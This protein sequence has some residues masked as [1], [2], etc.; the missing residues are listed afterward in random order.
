M[1]DLP[2]ELE[3]TQEEF[4]SIERGLVPEEMEDKWFAFVED[5]TLYWHRSW[6]G[7]C[8]YAIQFQPIAGGVRALRARVCSDTAAYRAADD[9]AEAAWLERLI[10]TWLLKR[11]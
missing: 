9:H 2:F 8:V 4:R 5:W 11:V 3:C 6:T 10:R 1:R 7:L